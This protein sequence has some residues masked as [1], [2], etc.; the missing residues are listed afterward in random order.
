MEVY[1]DLS[2]EV[3]NIILNIGIGTR[4]SRGELPR[5]GSFKENGAIQQRTYVK[6]I[7]EEWASLKRKREDKNA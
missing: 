4:Y 3:P 6:E 1:E 7:V 2:V 5:S